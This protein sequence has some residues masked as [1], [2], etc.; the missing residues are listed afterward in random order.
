M[1]FSTS[2][3]GIGTPEYAFAAIQASTGI[4]MTPVWSL[5]RNAACRAELLNLGRLHHG[6]RPCVFGDVLDVIVDPIWRRR[7]GCDRGIPE[8][9]PAELLRKRLPRT[10]VSTEC[11]CF[12]HRG[13]THRLVPTDVHVAGTTCTDH[14]LLGTLNRGDGKNVKF[15]FVWVAIMREL[16]PPV[17]VH[18][19]VV[20]FGFSGLQADLGDLY[21]ICP[22][23]FCA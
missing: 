22:S 2:Y 13:V 10:P 3:S 11:K 6:S 16:R 5:E 19:N 7:L 20:G 23:R 8:L 18:E 17:I 1:T 14:S 4:T 12:A 21:V 9:S 15:Y